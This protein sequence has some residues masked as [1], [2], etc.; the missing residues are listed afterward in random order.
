MAL[1]HG[2]ETCCRFGGRLGAYHFGKKTTADAAASAVAAADAEEMETAA[3]KACYS[4]CSLLGVRFT[5]SV[6]C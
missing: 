2:V 3:Q 1:I 4:I 5:L 6:T